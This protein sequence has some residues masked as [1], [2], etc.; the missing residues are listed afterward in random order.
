M[1]VAALRPGPDHLRDVK[2]KSNGLSCLAEEISRRH[3]SQPMGCNQWDGATHISGG[4]PS[5]FKARVGKV[6]RKEE[7][8]E[9]EDGAVVYRHLTLILQRIISHE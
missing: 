4:L 1:N 3:S 7:E 6:F 9:E 8:E 5:A 2:F